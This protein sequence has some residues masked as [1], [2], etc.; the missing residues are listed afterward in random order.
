MDRAAYRGRLVLM[1]ACPEPASPAAA[2]SCLFPTLSASSSWAT[3][4]S[5][6]RFRTG[7][8][9]RRGRARRHHGMETQAVMVEGVEYRDART[10]SG[11]GAT[12]ALW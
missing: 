6:F 11:L 7:A 2:G 8:R 5:F 3:V 9:A 12:R 4:V 1:P 10:R